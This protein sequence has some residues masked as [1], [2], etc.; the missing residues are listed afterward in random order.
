[1]KIGI[2]IPTYQRKDSSTP[3]FLSRALQSIKD[4]THDDYKVFLIGDKYE[5]SNEFEQL[6][7]SV[8][9]LEKILYYNL[10]V[11]V[12]RER[13]PQGGKELWR[14]GGANARNY[15]IQKCLEEGY[16]YA[17]HLDH[18]DYWH[19]QHLEVINHTISLTNN[20][21]F[22]F[23]RSTY[24]NSVLPRIGTV[25]ENITEMLPIPQGIVHSSVCINHSLIPFKYRDTQYEVGIERESDADMWKRISE[26]IEKDKILKSYF[27]PMLTCFHPQEFH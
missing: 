4:Q 19:P 8:I 16:N 12:E 6:A 15:G 7:T 22:L 11:A 1:M 17:C 14:C 25:N 2:V 24:F 21:A 3:F 23:T 20:P 18:D 9:P 5:D 27:I 26:F 13:Y 10:P